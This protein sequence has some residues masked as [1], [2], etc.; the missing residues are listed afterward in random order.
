MVE[1]D[2]KLLLVRRGIDPHQGMW[3][4][5]AGFVDAGEDPRVAAA[6]ECLE[7]TGLVITIFELV[8]VIS[9]QE[10][11]RG[12]HLVILFRAVVEGGEMRA[13]DDAD[14]AA[15]FGPHEVPPLAFEATKKAVDIWLRSR[16]E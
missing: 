15:F 10:H 1:Q 9:G 14:E 6:R 5:P 3:T 4:L 12:A 2:G 13:G 11:D 16:S 7:E 8:E